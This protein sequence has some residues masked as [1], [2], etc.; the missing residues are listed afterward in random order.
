ML[1]NDVILQRSITGEI[2]LYDSRDKFHAC[3]KNNQWHDHLLF[4]DYELEEF[5]LIEDDSEIAEVL[6]EARAAL[7]NRTVD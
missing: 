1:A 3:L 5:D 6:S 7:G 2:R 4:N